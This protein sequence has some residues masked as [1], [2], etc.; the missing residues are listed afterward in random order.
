MMPD[1]VVDQRVIEHL[2]A[3][4]GALLMILTQPNA[5][6][7]YQEFISYLLS[8]LSS[9][10]G[11]DS[12]GAIVTVGRLG[13]TVLQ[14]STTAKHFASPTPQMLTSARCRNRVSFLMYWNRNSS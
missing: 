5:T 2:A 3:K 7:T 9:F 10:A 11:Y 12:L 8:C 1:E 13:I 14:V 6:M 4:V